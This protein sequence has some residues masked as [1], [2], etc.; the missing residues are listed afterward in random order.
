MA[1][2]ACSSSENIA[3]IIN[4]YGNVSGVTSVES[5]QVYII[6][7]IAGDGDGPGEGHSGYL[8]DSSVKVL[9]GDVNRFGASRNLI[10]YIYGSVEGIAAGKN[11]SKE[12]KSRDHSHFSLHN[13]STGI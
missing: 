9:V 10:A 5:G 1:S 8:R 2:L 6:S 7:G 3:I 13:C 11:R 12:N 4:G